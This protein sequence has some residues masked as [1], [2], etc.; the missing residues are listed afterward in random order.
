MLTFYGFGSAFGLPDP[1]PFVMSEVQLKMAGVPYRFERAAPP[2]GPKGKIPFIESGAHRVGD[3]TF[4][5]AYIEKE[6]G[7]DFRQGSDRRTTRAC[8]GN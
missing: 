8:L 4:I 1:S 6:H 5:R 3:S 2:D 7:F